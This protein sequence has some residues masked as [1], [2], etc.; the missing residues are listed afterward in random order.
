MICFVLPL[1]VEFRY[2]GSRLC[3]MQRIALC[4]SVAKLKASVLYNVAKLTIG[5]HAVDKAKM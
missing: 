4:Y 5:K 2:S 1:K 3:L